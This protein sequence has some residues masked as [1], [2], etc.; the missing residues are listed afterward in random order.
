ML[1]F[2]S[3]MMD[4]LNLIT[5]FLAANF[6]GKIIFNLICSFLF[7]LII[8]WLLRPKLLIS[9]KICVIEL[10]GKKYF[11]YKIVNK[12]IFNAYDVK[13]SLQRRTPY[14]VSNNKVNYE[15]KVVPLIR[16]EIFYIPKYKSEKGIGEHSILIA[17][18]EDLS[19]DIHKENLDYELSVS[20]KH[21]LSNITTVFHNRYEDKNSL[22]N[23]RFKF[24]KSLDVIK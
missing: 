9:E 22:H 18:L 12:S 3:Y 24:G 7:I 17:T 10:Y 8:L 23:G 16:S 19:L 11:T 21:G 14:I 2:S 4:L 15:M 1:I 5:D 20:A 13:F 6:I